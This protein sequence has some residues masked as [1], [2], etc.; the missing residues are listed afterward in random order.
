M[1]QGRRYISI[2]TALV[3]LLLQSCVFDDYM[4]MPHVDTQDKPVMLTLQVTSQMSGTYAT[5][6]DD[7]DLEAALDPENY[8]D[9]DDYKIIVYDGEGRYIQDFV[10]TERKISAA[11][12]KDKYTVA[13]SGP[14]EIVAGDIQVLVLANWTHF[15]ETTQYPSDEKTT[16]HN[17]YTDKTHNIFTMRTAE[18][19]KP[20]SL[21]SWAPDIA[22]AQGIPMFGVSAM[23][24]LEAATES[25]E[26]RYIDGKSVK[27]KVLDMGEIKMLR[28]LSKIEVLLGDEIEE[29]VDIAHVSLSAFNTTGRF[30]PDITANPHWNILESQVSTPTLPAD[31]KQ[32][33]ADLHFFR[34]GNVLRAYVPEMD[35]RTDRP[36]LTIDVD[37]SRGN[38]DFT[39]QFVIALDNPLKPGT[40]NYLLR[41]HI[42]RYCIDNVDT[43]GEINAKLD[44]DPWDEGNLNPG[45]GSDDKDGGVDTDP[46]DEGNLNPGHGSDD[47]DGGVDTDPWDEGNLNPGNGSGDKDGGVDTDPWDEGNLNPGHGSSDKDGGVDTDPW[48]EGNL[49]PG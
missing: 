20:D 48:D 37:W 45:H 4:D 26:S 34:V 2:L 21:I 47:K 10:P 35:L 32:S 38:Y 9:L 29:R 12:S 41:N 43:T 18:A 40:L 6:S 23:T 24:S 17:L 44:V 31:V 11:N 7:H 46:W 42:Y 1:I 36:S 15:D 8:L 33:G 30:I 16:L 39:K 22:K 14:L 25:P 19:S 5:R 3:V 28:A 13:L 49:N 27:I